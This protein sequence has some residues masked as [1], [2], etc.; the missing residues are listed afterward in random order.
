MKMHSKS[1]TTLKSKYCK[2]T[3]DNENVDDMFEFLGNR[4]DI[5]GGVV[6][7]L[8]KVLEDGDHFETPLMT[9]LV[10]KRHRLLDGN[11]RIEAV[12]KYLQKYPNRKIEVFVFYYTNLNPDMEKQMYTKW[13][14]GIKQNT[15][16]FVRQYWDDIPLA[17]LFVGDEKMPC[18]VGPKWAKGTMEF[19]TLLAGYLTKDKENWEGAY[20]GSAMDFIEE[21]QGF[22]HKAFA[23]LKQFLQEYT[24]VFGI[25]NNKN[26]HY[27]QAVFFSL[28]KIWC[29][30]KAQKGPDAIQRAFKRLFMHERVQYYSTMGG[31]REN[32]KFCRKDLLDVINGQKK[33]DLFK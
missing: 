24:L 12:K 3:L 19:K 31:T 32:C 7:R 1:I 10:R 13:N 27:K 21:C 14:L 23:E 26:I 29:D 11:H 25:P 4:R 5:R 2:I 20:Y 15:N 18:K 30:N 28:I 6:N 9:N 8:V 22:G 17:Q 16:D 33:T